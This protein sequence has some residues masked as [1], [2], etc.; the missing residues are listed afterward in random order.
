[1]KKIPW[2]S[3]L[4]DEEKLGLPMKAQ[5][6]SLLG[7]AYC[8]AA[9]F[10]GIIYDN[11]LRPVPLLYI[12]LSNRP[13]FIEWNYLTR[14]TCALFFGHS[15]DFYGTQKRVYK[16]GSWCFALRAKI[17]HV[18]RSAYKYTRLVIDTRSTSRAL[19]SRASLA[20]IV[21]DSESSQ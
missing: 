11:A 13:M 14:R 12:S 18:F 15:L 21:T 8:L 16:G 1:M 19:R 17:K 10:T 9:H 5:A 3:P 7:P 6:R 4:G 20:F 2:I